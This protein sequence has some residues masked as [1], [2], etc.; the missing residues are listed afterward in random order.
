MSR[1]QILARVKNSLLQNSIPSFEPHF[2]DILEYGSN[3]L[4]EYIRFQEG[5]R[6]KV[7]RS[8]PQNLETDIA[9]TLLEMESKSILR[10]LDLPCKIVVSSGVKIVDY[11]KSVE[12]L[13]KELFE[14]D[15]AIVKAVCAVANLG[16]VGTVS[17][18][19]S[20]RLASLI[21]SNCIILLKSDT[22]VANLFEGTKVLKASANEGFLPTNMLFIA[23][24]SRTA[25][26][27]LQTVF[28]VHGPQ[29]VVVILY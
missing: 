18:P 8:C 3:L 16:V 23:G 29:N 11:D 7:I 28:G 19:K 5:N 13:R 10:T 12:A 15:T 9:N 20:P 21:T 26:I 25:D 1:V 24:P 2:K 22:I 27:E 4:E 6:A 17:S 14:I